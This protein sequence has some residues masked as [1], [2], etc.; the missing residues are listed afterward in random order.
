MSQSIVSCKDLTIHYPESGAQIDG[1]SFEI[2][3]GECFALVG[4]SG[5]GKTTITKALL[6]LHHPDTQIGGQIL[7]DGRDLL[8]LRQKE[9]RQIRGVEI[10]YVSQNPWG[11]CD[12][13]REVADHIGQAWRC[14]GKSVSRRQIISELEKIG[15][16]DAQEKAG[17]YPHQWSG[18]M[19]QRA[20]I[21]AATAHTPS[22]IIA[23]EPTS[24]LDADLSQAVLS[25]I[26]QRSAAVLLV[27][28]DMD[29]V[30]QN[31][32]R[33][34]VLHN[35]QLVEVFTPD[36]WQGHRHHAVTCSFLDAL[37]DTRRT[38]SSNTQDP[39]VTL[40]DASLHYKGSREPILKQV[41][42]SIS[43]GEIIGILGP[44]GS[45]KSSL[46]KLI[47][48]LHECSSGTM[49][50][51][52]S[53]TRPGAIMPIFQDPSASLPLSW[54]VW[55]VVSEPLTA[56]H[57]RR[58]SRARRR[59]AA[60]EA[61]AN[62]GLADLDIHAKA[63]ELSIGQKQRVCLSRLELAEPELIVADE[64]TSSLDTISCQ[65]VAEL[66]IRL[67]QKGTAILVVSHNEAFLKRICDRRFLVDPEH[68]RL[69]A[70]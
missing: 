46:L 40:K 39:I 66:L 59:E 44:S 49:H 45:G 25:S 33:I 27:S 36:Q 55:R 48:G 15:V 2:A 37:K 21:A 28:H 14:Q 68:K 11:A 70:L 30:M 16:A 20:S 1:V 63:W 58:S 22:L 29:L 62:V 5:S 18:G 50:K 41:D 56:S 51:S 26:R 13:R 9:W 57:L 19:L 67:A 10:G 38:T 6:G 34:G 42:L 53:L 3:K 24:A 8:T 65:Q 12:P 23:D 61:L 7:F 43:P 17:A 60:R 35:G 69:V 52:M 54:P 64:P 4:R 47:M 32:D 31:A